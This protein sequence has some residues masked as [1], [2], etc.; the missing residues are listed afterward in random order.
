MGEAIEP[1]IPAVALAGGIDQCQI[2]RLA[3]CIGRLALACEIKL[4]QRQRDFLCE[5]D[6]DETAGGVTTSTRL[7][8]LPDIPTVGEFVPGYEASGW[9]GIG[10]PKDTPTEIVDELNKEINAGLADPMIKARIADVGG[11]VLGGTSD[12][13]RILIADETEKWAKVIKFANL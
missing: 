4:L 5:S 3:L 7:E 10:A 12:D 1:A 13:F 6:A 8:A 9:F 2:A 11:T